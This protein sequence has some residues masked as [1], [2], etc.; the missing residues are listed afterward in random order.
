LSAS[1]VMMR[2]R[3]AMLAIPVPHSRWCA[4]ACTF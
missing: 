3:L 1:S 4:Q 2:E